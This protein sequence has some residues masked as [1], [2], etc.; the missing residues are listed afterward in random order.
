MKHRVL[1]LVLAALLGAP[2]HAQTTTLSANA[3]GAGTEPALLIADS[4]F[5][6]SGSRL[7]ATGNVEA[8]QDGLRMVAHSIVFDQDSGTL[9]IEGPIRITDSSGNLLL[10][11][12]A[13]LD[14]DF[15]NGLLRG[16]RM[17]MDDQLQLAA[18]DAQRVEGRYTQLNRVAVTS[19]QVC[20]AG[21]V[22]LWQIRA[23]RVIHDEDEK[24]LWFE[25]AQL[26]VLDVPVFWWPQLRLPDPTLKRA[27]GFLTPTFRS[28]TLLGTGIRLPYFIPIGD[29]QDITLTP[30]LASETRTLEVIY[31]RA[32]VDGAIEVNGAVSQDTLLED[33]TRGY[34]FA[35]GQFGLGGGFELAF[36]LQSVSDDSYFNAYDYGDSDEQLTSEIRVS[37]YRRDG[38]IDTGLTYYESLL[39]AEDDDKEPS[40]IVDSAWQKRIFPGRIGGQ[41]TLGLESHGH[42][43][44]SND[45]TDGNDD[46]S[47]VDG[48]DMTRLSAE[49]HWE[50]RWTL[51]AGVRA[52][53]DTYLWADRYN[54]YDDATSDS[55]ASVL[56]PAASV[57]L[58]WPLVRRAA[59]GGRTLLEPVVMSGWVGAERPNIPNDESTR[60]EFD[61]ANLL[62]LSRFAAADRRERG[63]TTAAGLRWLHE[64]PAGWATRMTFGRVWRQD[65]DSDLSLSSGLNGTTSDWLISGGFL[66][67]QGLSISIRGLLDQGST[68]DKAEARAAW[69]ND[70][71]DISATYLMLVEDPDEDRDESQ[72]ELT[73]DGAYRVSR[74]WTTSAEWRYDLADRR[75]DRSGVGLQYRNECV[76]VDLTILR[77]FASST[78]LEPSTDFGLSVALTGFGTAGSDKEY[79]RTCN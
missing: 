24:Q 38:Y 47:I 22:P 43:R 31:R 61:E 71:T 5:V 6:Q 79:R 18:I 13:E 63:R 58:R 40:V 16:A 48:R 51:L 45:D 67:P 65:D 7:V 75:V 4:V 37:R 15:R 76:Q 70:R 32:F 17:V 29:H 73:L 19:C 42:Y 74:H 10:A 56:T 55:A 11:D 3:D 28:T 25:G 64:A 27:R 23:D 46:D 44:R 35:E 33:K 50:R 68:F 52:G 41:L 77:E 26:R 72:A 59:L 8:L 60:V 30:Y 9:T 1:P 66:N 39:A 12:A 34:L 78:N 36:E 69:Y 2:L 62:S 53:I 57:E 14:Q 21:E 54:V 20:G 49:A